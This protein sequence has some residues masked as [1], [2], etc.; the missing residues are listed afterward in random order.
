MIRPRPGIFVI[1]LATL[2]LA[3]AGSVEAFQ[4]QLVPESFV[5]NEAASKALAAE[6]RTAVMCAEGHPSRCHRQLI[7]DVLLA[8]GRRVVNLLP[9]GRLE[10]HSL[11][12][13]AVVAGERVSYPGPPRQLEL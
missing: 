9:D 7:A 8:R 11:S 3:P 10:P 1:T 2:A 12:E 13:H 5:L 4:H 6:W